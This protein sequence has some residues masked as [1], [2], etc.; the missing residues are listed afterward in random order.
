ML[1]RT[2]PWASKALGILLG[3]LLCPHSFGETVTV[4]VINEKNGHPLSKQPV[5]VQF[6]YE[7]G[8]KVSE[9]NEAVLH[10]E[11]DS[12]GEAKF[13]IPQ[14]IPETLWVRANLTTE[15]WDCDC[16]LLTGTKEII[17]K[18]WNGRRNH[19]GPHNAIPGHIVFTAHPFT[20]LERLLYPLVK[21]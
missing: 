11:T 18:G 8:T 21:E 20:L 16:M 9:N 3:L 15:H 14:V 13:S 2:V 1:K 10:L 6:L 4:R 12:S 19:P 5:V 17:H 7:K